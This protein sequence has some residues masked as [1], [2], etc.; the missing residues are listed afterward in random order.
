MESIYLIVLLDRE[1]SFV[2]ILLDGAGGAAGAAR[3]ELEHEAG[4][5]SPT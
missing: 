5:F 2:D 4:L 3:V 1:I